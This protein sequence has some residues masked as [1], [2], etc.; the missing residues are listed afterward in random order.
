VRP[1]GWTFAAENGLRPRRP[2]ETRISL[3]TDRE[4]ALKVAGRFCPDPVAVKVFAAKARDQGVV[5]APFA[6]TLWLA[7]EIPAA[8]L[9]GPKVRPQTEKEPKRKPSPPETPEATLGFPLH[10]PQALHG[11]KKG[12]F[13]DSPEWKNQTRR[14][15]RDGKGDR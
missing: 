15:R 4:L 1:A 11:K 2:K 6:E 5:F 10:D 9:S 12:R 7:D 13:G 14:D 8:F 3:F